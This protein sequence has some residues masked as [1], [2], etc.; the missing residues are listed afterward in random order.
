MN[1]TPF[2]YPLEALPPKI[3]AAITE[4]QA[5]LQA[6]V[7]IIAAAAL[8]SISLAAQD[9]YRVRWLH[10]IESP[11]GLFFLTIAESG[12][13]K[14]AA[15]RL[16]IGTHEEQQG[17][18]EEDLSEAEAEWEAAKAIWRARQNGLSKAISAN[19]KKG[20][21]VT[22]L[23]EQ[24]AELE[25]SKP[26]Q[27]RAKRSVFHDTTTEA[28]IRALRDN[29]GSA[30]V[31]IDEGAV[32]FNSRAAHNAAMLARI[33]SGDN[34]SVDRVRSESFT[35]IRPRL[36]MSIFTQPAAFTDFLRGGGQAWINTGLM[37]RF[38]ISFPL[39]TQGYR[40]ITG[41]T[42]NRQWLDAFNTRI[43]EVLS[44]NSTH[45]D[46]RILS[47]TPEANQ[48]LIQHMNGVEAQ[49]APW[50][51]FSDIRGAASKIAENAVRLAAGLHVFE[52]LQGP[53][54]KQMLEAAVAICGWHLSEFKRLFGQHTQ[55]TQTQQDAAQLLGWLTG[56]MSQLGSAAVKKNDIAQFG[57]NALR[58]S[59]G[60]REA[61]VFSLVA[62]GSI[63][64]GQ[65]GKT[66][67]VMLNDPQLSSPQIH[68][69]VNRI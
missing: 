41:Q 4:A 22:Q 61:A 15:D 8:S 13:R 39:S 51:Y 48:S 33:W 3:V 55:L 52:G 23:E 47:L 31:M 34:I 29:G 40:F 14:T 21:S 44:E 66:A 38:L 62:S 67:Y 63:R 64:L 18:A 32:F 19:I 58:G 6:P 5:I 65:Y 42:L 49:L 24:L 36:T 45:R 50:G 20:L 46:S 17:A 12:E 28:L 2:I 60:R 68:W 26:K 35:L 10:D 11:I 59:R 25:R 56:R 37:S 54:S 1:C 27:R 9:K 7:P 16:F 69:A 57:P 53:I 43:S 30:G